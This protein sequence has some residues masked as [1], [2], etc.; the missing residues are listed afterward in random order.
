MKRSEFRARRRLISARLYRIYMYMYKGK[1][2]D[3]TIGSKIVSIFRT[4][5]LQ[6]NKTLHESRFIWQQQQLKVG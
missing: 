5:V 6:M 3:V 2:A 4:I 1:P